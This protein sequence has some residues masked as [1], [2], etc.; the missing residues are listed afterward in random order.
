ME[1][2]GVDMSTVQVQTRSRAENIYAWSGTVARLLVGGVLVAA[3]YL[4]WREPHVDQIRAVQAYRLISDLNVVDLV[5]TTLPILEMLVG[6]LLLIG[7]F[8]RPAAAISGLV[9]MVFIAGIA[10]VWVRGLN[11]DCG[12]F[13]SGGITT[14]AGRDLRYGSE[15][16]RDAGLLLCCAWLTVNPKSRVALLDRA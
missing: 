12:C 4:K 1:S 3:G 14:A 2:G 5:A 11:I 10:S 13:G 7:L 8:V 6:A 15:I 16:A 9:M